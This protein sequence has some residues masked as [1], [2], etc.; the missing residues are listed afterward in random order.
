MLMRHPASLVGGV[1][2]ANV[3]SCLDQVADYDE[4]SRP[5]ERQDENH[6]HQ[7]YNPL[8]APSFKFI[9]SGFYAVHLGSSE[10]DTVH[11]YVHGQPDPDALK[12]NHRPHQALT[13]W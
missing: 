5:R 11:L 12:T 8:E 2:Q 10:S 9:S 1:R 3:R 4:Q 7:G 13:S 6:E